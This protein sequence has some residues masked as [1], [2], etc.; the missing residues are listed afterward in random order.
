M[1]RGL[2]YNFSYA[3]NYLRHLYDLP[4]LSCAVAGRTFTLKQREVPCL[5][6]RHRA[7]LKLLAQRAV[8]FIQ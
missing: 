1:N 3:I 6:H 4:L 7:S 8:F 5:H 2:S